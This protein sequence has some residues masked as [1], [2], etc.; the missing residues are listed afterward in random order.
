M[1]DPGS[2]GQT[3]AQQAEGGRIE[4]YIGNVLSKNCEVNSDVSTF[5]LVL[6]C[7]LVPGVCHLHVNFPRYCKTIQ[8]KWYW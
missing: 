8:Q 1:G 4:S 3:I 2:A 6:L 5:S 7:R